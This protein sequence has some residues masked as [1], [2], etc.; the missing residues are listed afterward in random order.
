MGLP[1]LPDKSI[2]VC[3]TNPP[4]NKKFKGKE[5]YKN[6]KEK[7]YSDEN[8]DYKNWCALFFKELKRVCN[9]IL[10]H[11]GKTNINM[12]FEIEPPYELILYTV[13]SFNF[14]MKDKGINFNITIKRYDFQTKFL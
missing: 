8:N 12:W 1:N 6:T 13:Q 10:I 7:Y 3:F 2:D 4:F 14:T 5:A 9:I 11:C